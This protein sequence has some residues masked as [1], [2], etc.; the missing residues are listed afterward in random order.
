MKILNFD[1]FCHTGNVKLQYM[2]VSFKSA[3][4][5]TS[6][7]FGKV[8]SVSVEIISGYCRGINGIGNWPVF[9]ASHLW[10]LFEF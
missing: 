9:S 4:N 6:E 2:N 8:P 3:L 1:S 5:F 7:M 10:P